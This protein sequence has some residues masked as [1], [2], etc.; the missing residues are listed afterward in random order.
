MLE[1]FKTYR[2]LNLLFIGFAQILAAYF[3]YFDASIAELYIA[4]VHWLVMG[5]LGVASFGYWMN[6]YFDVERDA[7]NQRKRFNVRALPKPVLLIHLLVFLLVVFYSANQLNVL[8]SICFVA[9][10]LILWLYNWKLK[11]YAFIGN[12]LIALL[13]F[14]SV[15]MLGWLF[16]EIDK[17]LLLHF[18]FLAGMINFCRELI[19]DGEDVDG[20]KATGAKTIPVIWGKETTNRLVYFGVLFIVSF[21]IISLYY[22]QQYF[23]GAL[24]Y[25]Y[26]AYN[27]FFVIIPLYSI[28]L[29]VRNLEQK[30]EYSKMSREFKYVLFTGILSILFF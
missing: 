28:A 3:L 23:K 11:D 12:I 24:M 20:D 27:I 29:N 16:P 19:K 18:A 14:V 25:L 15:F 1:Y 30:S 8:I 6:D 21:V 4:G 10:L 9:S 5:T 26:W 13:S 2:P 17:R 22:Q 7:I